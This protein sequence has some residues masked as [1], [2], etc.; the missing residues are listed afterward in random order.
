MTRIRTILTPLLSAS[1][2]CFACDGT[3]WSKKTNAKCR[4]CK[5]TGTI[6]G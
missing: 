5:G 6:T 1:V 3:G 2:E 4:V